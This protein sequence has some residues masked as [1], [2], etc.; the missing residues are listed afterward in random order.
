MPILSDQF[1]LFYQPPC[2]NWYVHSHKL[3]SSVEAGKTGAQKFLPS[4]T[5]IAVVP[6]DIALIEECAHEVPAEAVFSWCVHYS[7]EELDTM[8]RAG[9]I[10][11]CPECGAFLGLNQEHDCPVKTP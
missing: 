11:N 3:Y 5:R 9:K 4:G 6:A 2:G 1:I 10:K 8:V 7:L